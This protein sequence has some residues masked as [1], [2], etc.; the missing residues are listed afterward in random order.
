MIPVDQRTW[1]RILAAACGAWVALAL[2]RTDRVAEAIGAG[3]KEVRA[4]ALRD[5][6]SAGALLAPGHERTAIASR[7]VLDVSDAVRYGRGR[8]KLRAGILAFAAF[9]ALGLA[10]R[11]A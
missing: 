11:R 7:V 8:P 6:A 9:G 2:L 5:L 3:P 4:L 10:A 1:A